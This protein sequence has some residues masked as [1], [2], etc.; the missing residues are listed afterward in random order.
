MAEPLRTILGQGRQNIAGCSML[1]VRL[2]KGRD[3]PGFANLSLSAGQ[4][5]THTH[6]ASRNKILHQQTWSLAVS[7]SSAAKFSGNR[8]SREFS[9]SHGVL[10]VAHFARYYL[11]RAITSIGAL[12][13]PGRHSNF[14]LL[15]GRHSNF[16]LLL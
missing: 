2:L 15:S 14:L 11:D 3:V 16:L 13:Y 4:A 10:H 5:E 7:F 1:F 12:L 9:T 6:R 8:R